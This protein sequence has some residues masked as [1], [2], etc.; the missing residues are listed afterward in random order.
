MLLLGALFYYQEQA[1][2]QA[3]LI[4]K[5]GARV[6]RVDYADLVRCNIDF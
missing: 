1:I 5:K 6:F 4:G 3:R 2:R